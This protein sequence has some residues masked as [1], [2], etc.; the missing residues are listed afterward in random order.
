LKV[1]LVSVLVGVVVADGWFVFDGVVD[2]LVSRKE[3]RPLTL[4][5]SVYS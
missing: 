1:S 5:A 2:N 4:T 3:K